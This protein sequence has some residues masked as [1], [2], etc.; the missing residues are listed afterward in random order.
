[1]N[2]WRLSKAGSVA[3]E[4]LIGITI[5]MM[6][7]LIILGTLF[8]IYIDDRVEWCLLQTREDVSIYAIPFLEQDNIVHKEVNTI[9][10]SAAAKHVFNKAT[11]LY[12][13]DRLVSGNDK[14]IVKFNEYGI[15]DFHLNYNYL[16]PSAFMN[17][18]KVLPLSAAIL[19]DGITFGDRIVY[20]TTYGEKFHKST[21]FHLRKSKFGIELKLAKERGY[22]PCKNCHTDN[23]TEK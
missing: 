4:A 7:S 15:A 6:T 18:K 23:P 8:T 11:E 19:H 12:D 21:C 3:L 16:I 9:V 10:L 17:K 13:I 1:M 22:E 14:S 20:I 5:V 2:R